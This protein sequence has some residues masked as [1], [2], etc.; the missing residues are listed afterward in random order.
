MASKQD[1]K[2]VQPPQ[3]KGPITMPLTVDPSLYASQE[4]LNKRFDGL[5][6]SKVQP[7]HVNENSDIEQIIKAGWCALWEDNRRSGNMQAGYIG[8]NRADV[9][10]PIK[11]GEYQDAMQVAFS[12]YSRYFNTLTT[13]SDPIIYDYPLFEEDYADSS[14]NPFLFFSNADLVRPGDY[15]NWDTWHVGL[16]SQAAQDVIIK[17]TN[18]KGWL[19]DA[20]IDTEGL[21]FYKP[22]DFDWS[23]LGSWKSVTKSST[24]KRSLLA[25]IAATIINMI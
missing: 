20:L 11:N 15:Y 14:L 17:K 5:I 3:I 8:H 24:K 4:T 2:E 25:A 19:I 18:G 1:F 7:L 12:F 23:S 6:F 13:N 9:Y 22:S 16:L 21:V 10:L